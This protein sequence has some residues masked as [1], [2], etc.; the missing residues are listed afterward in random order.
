[1]EPKVYHVNDPS[2]PKGC[3]F[4]GRSNKNPTTVGRYGNP[5]T[6]PPHTR[7]EACDLFR[8]KILPTLDV[9]ALRGKNL[10]C[11]CAPIGGS[12]G[13]DFAP[14]YRCHGY[15]ILKKANQ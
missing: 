15:D 12:D 2:R 10:V 14:Q 3:S 9:S 7:D 1:M 11:F 5:F 13:S 6:I 8:E 4:I